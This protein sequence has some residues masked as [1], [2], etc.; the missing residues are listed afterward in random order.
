MLE[1]FIKEYLEVSNGMAAFVW[2]GGKPLLAGLDFFEKIVQ[3]QKKY[4]EPNMRISNSVQTNATLIN[5]E[6]AD[7]FKKHD[8]LIGVSLDGP[9]HI[10]DRRRVTGSGKGSFNQVM[11]GVAYLREK[12][13]SFN[14][15]SVIHEDNVSKARD[16][17]DF[18]NEQCFDYVQFI[19]CMDFR[20]QETEKSGKY[21]ITAEEYGQFLCESFDYWFNDGNPRMSVRFFDNLLDMYLHQS[22]E[23]CIHR[24]TCPKMLILEQNGDAYP[25]DFFIHDDYKLGNVGTDS[26]E[27]ILNHPKYEAFLNLKPSLPDKCKKCEYL[28]FCHGG[29]P[30]S[31]SNQGTDV[32]YFCESYKMLYQYADERMIKLTK[33]VK[34]HWLN[35]AFKRG[36]K[37]PLRNDLCLCRS[38]K[39]F[40]KC[41]GLLLKDVNQ[42]SIN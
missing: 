11:R 35:E 33:K 22:A 23:L 19:P 28:N 17:L 30:R 40:K 7:F 27:N 9:Q 8:F 31:R 4:A 25:C 42:A 38:G 37:L 41:C 5:R 13:V 2:Q 14:I 15:L 39:K 29:C 26:L 21:L 36:V 32:D 3:L 6:W 34:V 24:E 12:K 16:L 1:K 20:A 18:Y 10:H